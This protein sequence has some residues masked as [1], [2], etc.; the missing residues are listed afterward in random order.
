MDQNGRPIRAIIRA[1]TTADCCQAESLRPGI[2]TQ[3]LLTDKGYD[4]QAI[5]QKAYRAEMQ[6]V[7]APKED[8][9]CQR[10]DDHD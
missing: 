7:I 10:N 3:Y 8:R 9:K 5:F 6:P 1:G 4:S 2:Q